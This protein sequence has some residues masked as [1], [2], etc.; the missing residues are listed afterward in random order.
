MVD[1]NFPGRNWNVASAM[2]MNGEAAMQI[3]GDWAKDEFTNAGKL[4]DAG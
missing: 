3:K 4:P 1:P 2:V